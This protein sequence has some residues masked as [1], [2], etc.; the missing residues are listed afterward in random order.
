LVIEVLVLIT[1]RLHAAGRGDAARPRQGGS[2]PA[3]ER[4]PR[5]SAAPRAAHRGQ[6]GRLQSRRST[7]TGNAISN[8]STVCYLLLNLELSVNLRGLKQPFDAG[9]GRAISERDTRH[10]T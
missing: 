10:V 4:Y 9:R 1:G 6:E 5:E 7:L 3:G 8:K 2:G